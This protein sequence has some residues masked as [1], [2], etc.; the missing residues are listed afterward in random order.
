MKTSLEDISSVKKKLL[1]E[2]EAKEV[3]KKLNAAYRDLGKRAKISGF[4]PGKV[5]KKILERRFGNDVADDVTKDLIN[6]SF[7]KALQELDT[8][9]LGTP[10]LEKEALKQGQD[11]KYSAV[12]EIRPQ[13]EVK[14]YLGI[15]VEK[16]KS[17][18]PEEEVEAR[19]E[20]IRQANGNVKSIDEVRPIRKDDHAVLDYEVFESDS[21]LDDMKA[22]NSMLKVGSNELHPQ[23]EEGLIGLDK[24]AE[25]EIL[26][27]FEDDYAN[28]AL[29]GKSLRYKVKVVDIKEMIVP[30]L[31]DEF[32]TNLGG[33]FKDLED[34]RNKMQESIVN[35]EEGRIDREMKG[36]LLQKIT[37]PMDFETPQVLIE[38]ELDYALENFKQSISQ[39][40]TSLEQVGITE[41]KLRED[42]RPA[43]ERRVREMLVLEEIAQKDE[44]TVDE[45]DLKKGFEDMA[46]G[47]GQDAEIVRQ[48]YE[49]RGLTDTLKDKLVEEKTLKYLVENAKV[50]EVERD[51]LSENKT[52]EKENN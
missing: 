10:A 14:N 52:P 25:T 43:S 38:S 30:E 19:I 22:T 9:P 5:P 4:R 20:Q 17:S 40:G 23:F 44:I 33:D 41:E 26:V 28:A 1:I 45:E 32:V 18:I 42:F 24:D 12:I 46:A 48:Y 50:L 31:N 34:L 7:P 6:E 15:E 27:D 39:N 16:E 21:P 37:E 36:R 8:M 51:E 49:A 2:I 3:D 11:F 29:A 13:F 47:M 35:Q